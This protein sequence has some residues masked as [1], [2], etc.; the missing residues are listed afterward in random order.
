MNM[1]EKEMLAY[2]C[3]VLALEGQGDI[4]WGHVTL[5]VPGDPERLY[6]KPAAMGLEE[7]EVADL[8]EV[9]L[10]GRKVGGERPSHSEVF[11]HTGIMRARPEVSCVVHTHPPHAVAF[12][13]LDRPLL[14]VGHEGSLFTDSLPIFSETTDL[15]VTRELGEALARTLGQHNAALLRNH[16]LVTTGG[17][18]VAEAVMTALILDKAC[19]VQLLA[20]SA[21]GPEA[22]TDS[23]EAR[24]KK[25]RIYYPS[26]IENA[27][28][29]Y[30][31]AVKRHEREAGAD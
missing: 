13:S 11:I 17:S 23:E 5:R 27:F 29:Y 12:G 22:W 25:E 6:M 7:I 1:D 26:A 19:R 10:H 28:D 30:V 4:I 21:G 14:P 16:G 24:T 9:D 20:E 15:I 3:K 8:I 18:V 31:R 2:G